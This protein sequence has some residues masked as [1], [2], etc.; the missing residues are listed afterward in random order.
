MAA[1]EYKTTLPNGKTVLTMANSAEQAARRAERQF[2][3]G[4]HVVTQKRRSVS[5]VT[6][7]Q[8]K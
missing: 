6:R 8:C 4:K 5:N 7:R 3:G 1:K 2:Y